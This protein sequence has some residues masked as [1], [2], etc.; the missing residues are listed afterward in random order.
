MAKSREKILLIENDPDISDVI[1]RQ[2]L[3]PV[4]YQ[5]KVV[6]DAN[7]AIQEAV[8]LSPDLVILD[9]SLVGI[10]G[11]D[12]LVGLHAQSPETPIIV[13]AEKDEEND[14]M[15]A[16]RLG[17]SDYLFSPLRE[18]EVVAAVDRGLRQVRGANDRV[19]LDQRLKATNLEL[20]QKVHELKTMLSIGKAVIS[21][22]DQRLLFDKIVEGAIHITTA[23]IGWLLLRD[24]AKSS[25]YLLTSQ[26]KLP[27]TWAK[28]VNQPLDDGISS[29]V[30]LSGETLAIHGEPLQR[31][32]I[33]ALGKAAIVVPIKA[34][35][36]V[37]GLLIMVRQ[38]EKPFEKSEQSLLEAVGDYASISLVNARLF[39]ALRQNAEGSRASEK[40]QNQILET[41]RSTLQEELKAALFS[42]NLLS[43]NKLGELNKEQKQALITAQASLKRLSERTEKTLPSQPE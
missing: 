29:L 32:K 39:R 36:E 22:T 13:L 12:L 14:V 1:A 26:H 35:D 27:R 40:R 15:Q 30:A 7:Q 37:I 17:A 28:K 43:E 38:K 18:T 9:L 41:L 10:S 11:K 4:G 20:K 25:S 16:L 2:A 6:S 42:L 21:V 34:K 23:D 33:S 3:K 24:E 8:K 19:Q 5:V 31:F